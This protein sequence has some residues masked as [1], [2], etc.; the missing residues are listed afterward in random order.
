MAY[1][2]DTPIVSF[3]VDLSGE[4]ILQATPI[5]PVDP[6]GTH[7][8]YIQVD[9]SK[10]TFFTGQDGKG[11]RYMISVDASGVITNITG[12]SKDNVHLPELEESLGQ[13]S[14]ANQISNANVYDL[15]FS[16]QGMQR[17]IRIDIKAA[18][19]VLEP[20]NNT[21]ADYMLYIVSHALS[22]ATPASIHHVISP[23][24]YANAKNALQQAIANAMVNAIGTQTV[25]D[26]ILQAL[27]SANG[28]IV[29]TT[30][31]T[32][33]LSYANSYS[34]IILIVDLTNIRISV[35]YYG[36]NKEIVLKHIP[37]RL[38]LT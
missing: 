6:S 27:I 28:P 16:F 25:Q 23:E 30:A 2:N 38:H 3:V 26:A 19:T 11:F 24:S 1:F 17:H 21:I 4:P 34:S 20:P 13:V 33:D 32:F 7:P 10:T 37:V 12:L 14:W 36:S 31:G 35:S 8:L 29:N 9:A 18:E 15:R 5:E 22:L